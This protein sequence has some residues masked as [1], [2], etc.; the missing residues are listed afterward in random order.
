MLLQSGLPK[1]MWAEALCYA[2]FII[3]CLPR[4]DQ[5][6][7]PYEIL[8]GHHLHI[9]KI[10]PFG[11]EA[12]AHVHAAKRTKYAPKAVKCVFLGLQLNSSGF[13]LMRI[14]DSSILVSNEVIFHEDKF[15]LKPTPPSSLPAS[16]TISA[17]EEPKE[18]YS[19]SFSPHEL[20]TDFP[21]SSSL[22][23]S[24]SLSPSLSNSPFTSNW[25]DD[26]EPCANAGEHE[27]D[28]SICRSIYTHSGDISH[29]E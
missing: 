15:P 28:G 5:L 3:N 22:S 8:N 18:K 14:Q 17:W 2:A 11:C 9:C 26:P 19:T 20:V 12:W 7:S 27:E 24:S 10:K 23:L 13:R 29:F 16:S 1:Y 6:A 21:S 25:N 4:H